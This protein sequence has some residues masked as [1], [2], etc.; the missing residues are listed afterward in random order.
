MACLLHLA[1]CCYDSSKFVRQQDTVE[2]D[3]VDQD[4][5]LKNGLCSELLAMRR[6][7]GMGSIPFYRQDFVVEGRP[8]QRRKCI[9]YWC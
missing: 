3:T 5:L 2:Q 7:Q 9:S 4:K 6:Y 1:G 8:L